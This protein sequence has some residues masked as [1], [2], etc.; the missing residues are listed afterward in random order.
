MLDIRKFYSEHGIDY[1]EEGHK[2]CRPG[3]V[4]I[5]CPFC[6]GNE[7]LH[8]GFCTVQEDRLAGA[9]VCWRCGGHSQINVIKKLLGVNG[10]RAKELLRKYGGRVRV[11]RPKRRSPLPKVVPAIKLPAGHGPLLEN[12][13]AV[14]YLIKRRYDPAELVKTWGLVA[15]GP[16]GLYKHRI[17]LPVHFRGRIVSY[18]GR[19]YTGKAKVPYMACKKEDESVHHKDILG[20]LEQARGM[21]HAFLVEGMFDM[22]RLGPGAVCC[23]GISYRPPQVRLLANTFKSVTVVLDGGEEQA[24]AA[25]R[26]I[27]ADLVQRGVAVQ[28]VFLDDGDPDELPP[29]EVARL[30]SIK[31]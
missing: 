18:Q 3:W 11:K 23:F 7:G 25:S 5:P 22:F 27:C 19:D 2:H 26:R 9:F 4:N 29:Q 14:Q 8:L 12:R 15:C 13:G 20:G 28:E 6:T 24:R 16:L 31:P 1:A 10:K 30:L 21:D 17:I